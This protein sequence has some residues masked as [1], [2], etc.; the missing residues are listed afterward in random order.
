MDDVLKHPMVKAVAETLINILGISFF[1]TVLVMATEAHGAPK[2]GNGTHTQTSA[3]SYEDHK[4]ACLLR[5]RS[6]KRCNMLIDARK[7]L[8]D[9]KRLALP[10]Q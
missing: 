8:D 3:P 2:K 4:K 9:A 7:N 1:F 5:T 6:E 10:A